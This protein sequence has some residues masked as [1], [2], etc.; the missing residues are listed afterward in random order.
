MIRYWVQSANGMRLNFIDKHE[1]DE[2]IKHHSGSRMLSAGE[3]A[4]ESYRRRQNIK[5]NK[6]RTREG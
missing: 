3:I 2:F 5:G 6:P 4:T 1:R